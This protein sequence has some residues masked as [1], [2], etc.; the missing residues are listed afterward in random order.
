MNFSTQMSSIM[1]DINYKQLIKD[2]AFLVDVRTEAEFA[3]GHI[4]GSTNIPLHTI[5]N[6]LDQ[7]KNKTNIIVFCR[8]GGRSSQAKAYLDINGFKNVINGGT[9][10]FINQFCS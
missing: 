10:D 1:N 6:E 9:W 7:F 4:K 5:P 8:S 2:G 3:E